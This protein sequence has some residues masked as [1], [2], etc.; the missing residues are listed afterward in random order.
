MTRWQEIIKRLEGKVNVKGAE[1]GVERGKTASKL[2]AQPNIIE[3]MCIDLWHT[4]TV[5]NRWNKPVY[6]LVGRT[7]WDHQR[8]F[9]TFLNLA[10]KYPEKVRILTVD[11]QKASKII[12]N[13]HFD[14]VF[15]DAGHDYENVWADIRTWRNKIKHGGFLCGHDYG[16][17]RF[18]GVRE[19]VDE[20]FAQVKEHLPPMYRGEEW[21]LT[22][23]GDYTWF[24][25]RP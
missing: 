17:K 1:I 18:P 13:D 6:N 20:Y 22:L 19:A 7:E 4:H 11:S 24:A 3:Y 8:N 2:L 16:A 21:E 12:P 5:Y 25:S 10:A 23:G 9:T 15:I 14:F